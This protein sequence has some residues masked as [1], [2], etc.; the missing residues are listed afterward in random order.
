MT[1]AEYDELMVQHAETSRIIQ[2]CQWNLGISSSEPADRMR[3]T[4]ERLDDLGTLMAQFEFRRG[5]AARRRPA[6]SPSHRGAV[7]IAFPGQYTKQPDEMTVDEILADCGRMMDDFD[8]R[9][10]R[11]KPGATV[12]PFPGA[13]RD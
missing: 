10:G 11:S 12:V 13:P 8:A 3:R 7:V 5:A 2:Q 4:N 9:Q 1:E 6:A